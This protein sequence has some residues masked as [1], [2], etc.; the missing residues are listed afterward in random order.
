MLGENSI[1]SEKKHVISKN[2][3]N[4]QEMITRKMV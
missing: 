3:R 4:L 1:P 2:I